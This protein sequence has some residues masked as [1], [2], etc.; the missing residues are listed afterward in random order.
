MVVEEELGKLQRFADFLRSEDRK[1]FEDLL[2]QCRL[3]ASYASTMTSPVKAHPLLM[4]MMFGQHKQLM[5][6][7]RRLG[8][9]TQLLN[10]RKPEA[11][12]SLLAS[13]LVGSNPITA[14]RQQEQQQL[15]TI[16]FI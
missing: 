7:E 4:S 14:R 2:N 16:N 12:D 5:E 15:W 1:V 6:L 3:Y 10:S 13:R 11:Q 9:Q 8:L